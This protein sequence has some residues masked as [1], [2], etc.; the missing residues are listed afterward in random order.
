MVLT[1]AWD[2]HEVWRP[3]G[4][5]LNVGQSTLDTIEENHSGYH[6]CLRALIEV[7]LDGARLT[8]TARETMIKALKSVRVTRAL[9]GTY[10][11]VTHIIVFFFCC[12]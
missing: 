2:Y 6:D 3:L 7:W 9:A 4:R 10:S 11:V 8:D 1:L 12:C 5:E